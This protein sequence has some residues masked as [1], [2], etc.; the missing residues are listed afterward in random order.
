MKQ[1]IQ[2]LEPKQ[3]EYLETDREKLVRVLAHTQTMLANDKATLVDWVAISSKLS[4]ASVALQS[5][6]EQQARTSA[7]M[8]RRFT[9][10]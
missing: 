3:Q 8:K 10:L 2:V 9:A 7:R 5:D 1:T 4:R 6:R